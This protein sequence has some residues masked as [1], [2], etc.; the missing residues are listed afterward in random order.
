MDLQLDRLAS[1]PIERPTPLQLDA[2]EGK[3]QAAIWAVSLAK[4]LGGGEQEVFC[5]ATTSLVLFD[6]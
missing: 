4:R 2:I 6:G 3:A 1:T 5:D